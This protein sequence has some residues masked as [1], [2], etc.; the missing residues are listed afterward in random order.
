MKSLD[1]TESRLVPRL[2]AE[3][4]RRLSL[5]MLG[6]VL[7]ALGGVPGLERIAVATPDVEVAAAAEDLGAEALLRQDPGLNPAIEAAGAELLPDPDGRRLLVVLGDVAGSAQPED[8]R[9]LVRSGA[10]ARRGAGALGRRR[11]GRTAAPPPRRH[12]GPLRRGQ[13]QAPPRALRGGRRH[14]FARSR[15]ARCPSTSTTRTTS[16][17]FQ[18]HALGGRRIPRR[19]LHELGIQA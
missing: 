15:C 12:P 14:A 11:H 1:A 16:R 18:E 19:L 13:R 17:R 9:R 8:L 3:N 6:D 4:A 7:E 10:A 2:G 5:A